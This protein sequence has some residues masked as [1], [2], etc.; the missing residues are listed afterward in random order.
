M[1]TDTSIQVKGISKRY[2]IGAAQERADTLRDMIT[3]RVQRMRLNPRASICNFPG[4]PMGVRFGRLLIWFICSNLIQQVFIAIIS[5]RKYISV[6]V[7]GFG[8]HPCG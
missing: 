4:T 8:A 1:D 3:S 2:K 6:P 5:K 7:Q